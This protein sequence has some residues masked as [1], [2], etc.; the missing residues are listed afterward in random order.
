MYVSIGEGL[1]LHDSMVVF[2]FSFF[3]F[4]RTTSVMTREKVHVHSEVVVIPMHC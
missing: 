3:F 4:L 1:R 2:F